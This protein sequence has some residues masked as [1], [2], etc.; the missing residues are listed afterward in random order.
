MVLPVQNPESPYVTLKIDQGEGV[1]FAIDKVDE[2]QADINLMNTFGE[3]ATQQM[4]QVMDRNVLINIA[5]Q[6]AANATSGTAANVTGY[7]S[8]VGP[9]FSEFTTA[10][11]ALLAGGTTARG[12]TIAL[13]ANAAGNGTALGTTVAA[14][15]VLVANSAAIV[16]QILYYG[17]L[18]DENNAPD[19]GRFVILPAIYMQKLKDISQDFGK[20]YATG[21]SV[22]PLLSGSIPKIDR[23]E[24]LFSNNTPNVATGTQGA[25]I[26]F[27]QQYATTFATQIT[28]T[29]IIDNPFAWGK[30]Y[31][32]LQVYGFGVIKPQFLGVDFWKTAG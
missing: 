26:I 25:A 13:S 19:E 24:I 32:G 16:A 20:A 10:K 14:N 2:F 11:G 12:T 22:S 15:Q 9:T 31:Q 3:D 21:Q 4:A 1:S 5:A 29:R 7:V 28:E 30:L 6:G 8:G 23:F 17:Q 27:G 18:L